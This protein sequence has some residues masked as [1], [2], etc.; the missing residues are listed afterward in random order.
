M[1]LYFNGLSVLF[2]ANYFGRWW[3]WWWLQQQ[4]LRILPALP[5]AQYK[6]MSKELNA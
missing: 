1:Y 4:T 2:V 6:V 3:W 5:G